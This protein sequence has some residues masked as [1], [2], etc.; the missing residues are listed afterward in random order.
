M[1]VVVAIAAPDGIV[2]GSDSRTTWIEG[3]HHRI[4]TDTARKVFALHDRFGVATYGMAQIGPKTIH[5]LLDEFVAQQPAVPADVGTFASD[6]AAFFHGQLTAVL[7]AAGQTLPPNAWPLGFLVAGYDATGIAGVLE[8]RVPGQIV[9]PI[10]VA[11]DHLGAAW[12][13][14]TD[15]IRRLIKGFDHDGFAAS[16][17]RVS[18]TAAQKIEKLEYQL[19]LPMTLADAIDLGSFLIDTTVRMLRFSDGTL[20]AR[21]RAPSCGGRTQMLTLSRD[22]CRML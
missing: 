3:E 1:T 7:Q 14:Q 18:K 2:L 8:V 21:K 12:R 6:L 22:G 15:V 19:I 17:G 11:T 4:T 10:G 16:K 5:G 13:G 9:M 20:G